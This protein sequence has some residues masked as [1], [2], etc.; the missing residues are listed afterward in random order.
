MDDIVN[1]L[2]GE[3]PTGGKFLD[4]VQLV[5]SIH[6]HAQ[7]HDDMVRN[8]VLKLSDAQLN[9]Q[10]FF[11]VT[12][13]EIKRSVSAVHSLIFCL[14]PSPILLTSGRLNENPCKKCY[15]VCCARA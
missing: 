13:I 7:E 5:E 14:K 6:G 3:S 4:L 9:L 8:F 10:V 11:F 15:E 12:V 2:C 1:I